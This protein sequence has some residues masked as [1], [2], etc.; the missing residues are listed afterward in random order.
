MI[1]FSFNES[2]K[3]VQQFL[4]TRGSVLFQALA[5]KID[6]LHFKVQSKIVTGK[7]QGQVL[8][9]RTGK[10]AGSIRVI[11]ATITETT[12]VGYVQGGGGPAWYGILHEYG[13]TFQA[14]RHSTA[15]FAMVKGKLK[16][17]LQRVMKTNY[18]ITFP[19]RSFMRSTMD[20]MTSEIIAGLNATV[21]EVINKP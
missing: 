10:L 9:H 12:V 19:E 16:A 11:P 8:K 13:G 15:S 3:R 20:E 4:A 14:S 18:T 7:L 5:K 21:T 2:D 17:S 6:L 1:R